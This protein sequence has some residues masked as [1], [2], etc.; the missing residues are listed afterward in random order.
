MQL[1]HTHEDSRT[2]SFSLLLIRAPLRHSSS[3]YLQVHNTN[4]NKETIPYRSTL[5]EIQ[6]TEMAPS[7]LL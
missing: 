1:F 6:Q 2:D 3:L 5:G 7:E 4:V